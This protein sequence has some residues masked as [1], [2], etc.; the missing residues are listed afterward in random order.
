MLRRFGSA[1]VL[2]SL[3]PALLFALSFGIARLWGP[4]EQGVFVAGKAWLDLLV[5]VGCFGFPQSLIIAINRHGA[6]R[7]R[8]YGDA[9][10]YAAVS[11]LVLWPVS[12]FARAGTDV[13]AVSALLVAVGAAGVVLSN[14]WRGILLTVDD[15]MRFHLITS[16][17]AVAIFVLVASVAIADASRFAEFMPAALAGAGMLAA[18][19]AF[20]LSG[21]LRLRS[22]VG[23]AAD[24]VALVRDGGDFFLQ[25]VT[26]AMQSFLCIALIGRIA[27]PD[28]VGRF[29]MA[30]ISL[31]A[32]L[33]PVQMLSPMVFNRWT[34]A[35]RRSV[36][37]AGRN[38]QRWL[39]AGT[40]LVVGV[41]VAAMP[42]V[43]PVVLGQGYAAGAAAIQILLFAVVPALYA[44][45]AMMRLAAAGELRI[46][47]ISCAVRMFVTVAAAWFGLH[48]FDMAAPAA[49]AAGAWLIGETVAAVMAGWAIGRSR[50]DAA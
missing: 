17:P 28:E 30:Q 10:I 24:Y 25:A 18:L 42:T 44:R 3:S 4:A 5:A 27:G 37:D 32:L 11:V 23:R 46:N 26:T 13:G 1:I 34:R 15:G 31:Q 22:A 41:L 29:G 21:P 12:Y 19:L 49:L 2:Q 35:A 48:L 7:S 6:D 47:S 39:L 33:M 40:L 20:A 43:V 38:E 16:A 36:L 9:A 50:R 45:I 14:L 8:L